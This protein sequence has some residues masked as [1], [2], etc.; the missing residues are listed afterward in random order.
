MAIVV[1]CACYS[2]RKKKNILNHRHT[3][4]IVDKMHAMRF[5]CNYIDDVSVFLSVAAVTRCTE[6]KTAA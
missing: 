4:I 5:V 6:S 1:P 3:V 2:S